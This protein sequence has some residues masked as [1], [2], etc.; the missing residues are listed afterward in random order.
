LLSQFANQK[1]VVI[2]IPNGGVPLGIEIARALKA[3]LEVLVC[4][5]LALPMNQEGGLGALAEDGTLVIN[6][7]VIERDGISRE[8]IDYEAENVKANVR[9]RSLKYKSDDPPARLTGR[10]AII[11]DDG[12]ASGITMQVAVESV[13][14]RHPR[15]IVAAVP[16]ASS[17][18]Y[19]RATGAADKVFSCVIGT[20]SKFY[21]ADYY[22]HWRDIPDDE[23][24]RSL[25][26]WRQQHRI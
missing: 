19:K 7:D 10:V 21:L 25:Q 13:K 11:V 8:Q 16:I 26:I 12:L 14:H 17:T 2:A 20:Q 4:R 24:L 23:T 18:G 1:A 3:E 6:Q 9:A 5:K 15:E 22:R